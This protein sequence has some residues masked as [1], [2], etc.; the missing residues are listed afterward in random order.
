MANDQKYTQ[1][2]QDPAGPILR[3]AYDGIY[4]ARHQA[5]RADVA[6]ALRNTSI[7]TKGEDRQH[8]EYTRTP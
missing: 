3:M 7:F 6:L 4:A 5:G 8:P 2:D 1:V